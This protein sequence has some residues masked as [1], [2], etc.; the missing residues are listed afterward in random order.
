LP[1]GRSRFPETKAHVASSAMPSD[2]KRGVYL[3]QR[4]LH[5]GE[6]LA[7][8]GAEHKRSLLRI[9]GGQPPVDFATLRE[10]GLICLS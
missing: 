4:Q 5:L 6:A 10:Y 1:G 2:R 3:C 7:Q 9:L 8:Q